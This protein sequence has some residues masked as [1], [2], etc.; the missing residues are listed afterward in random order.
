MHGNTSTVQSGSY[1]L[2][3]WGGGGRGALMGA[4]KTPWTLG[5]WLDWGTNGGNTLIITLC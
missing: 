3:M 1:V 4:P 5:V 2:V